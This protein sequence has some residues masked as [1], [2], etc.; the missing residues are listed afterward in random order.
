MPHPGFAA[1]PLQ[2]RAGWVPH[3][4]SKEGTQMQICTIVFSEEQTLLHFPGVTKYWA[5]ERSWRSEGLRPCPNSITAPSLMHQ[6][7]PPGGEGHPWEQGLRP[8]MRAVFTTFRAWEPVG[9][10]ESMDFDIL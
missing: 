1:L 8:V 3:M 6:S 10:R 9:W 7:S 4:V 2:L 5:L